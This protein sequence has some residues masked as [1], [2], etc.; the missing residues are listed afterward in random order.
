M[1]CYTRA[2]RIRIGSITC[3]VI[4][5]D[6]H[7]IAQIQDHTTR[8]GENFSGR[9]WQRFLATVCSAARCKQRTPEAETLGIAINGVAAL[10]EPSWV[11][12]NYDEVW[13][14]YRSIA[15]PLIGAGSGGGQ[16][17]RVQ[18]WMRNELQAI[19]FDGVVVI[20]RYKPS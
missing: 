4:E 19:E 8:E 11:G 20:V 17:E 5:Q 10:D 18:E 9:T 16:A 1:A 13:H 14:G 2:A 3:V 6:R 12:E 7:R 15:F